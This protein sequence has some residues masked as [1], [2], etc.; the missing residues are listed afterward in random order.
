MSSVITQ[1]LTVLVPTLLFLYI[2]V[3]GRIPL[4]AVF[5]AFAYFGTGLDWHQTAG[6]LRNGSRRRA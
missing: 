1:F 2:G 6:R 3:W 5:M 4:Q